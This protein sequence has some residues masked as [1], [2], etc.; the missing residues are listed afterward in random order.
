MPLVPI[1]FLSSLVVL[2][3]AC[4]PADPGSETTTASESAE[5]DLAASGGRG[6]IATDATGYALTAPNVAR[7]LA[8]S[9]GA[10]SP[11]VTN[12]A[13]SI[14][15]VLR[16]T[17]STSP[18]AYAATL[19]LKAWTGVAASGPDGAPSSNGQ[20]WVRIEGA[21]SSAQGKMARA[22]YDAMT[23][24]TPVSENGAQVR[25][26]AKG[27]VWCA[28]YSSSEQ[29]FLGPFGYVQSR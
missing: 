22:I 10:G 2:G 9:I 3:V 6:V 4:A 23:A 26:S 25:R 24:V 20:L 8:A 11:F 7:E 15:N 19:E 27:S 14:P 5:S 12:G 1:A 13:V 29:C 18:Y 28:T 17:S 16:A 21:S